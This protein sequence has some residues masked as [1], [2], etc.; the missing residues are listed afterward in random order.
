MQRLVQIRFQECLTNDIFLAAYLLHPNFKGERLTAAQK[1]QAKD[2]I[3][4]RNS[5]FLNALNVFL[6]GSEP[7]NEGIGNATLRDDFNPAGWWK[8]GVL[9]GFN[10]ELAEFAEELLDAVASIAALERYFSTLGF[11]YG[12][13]RTRF[14]VDKAGRIATLYRVFRSQW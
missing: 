7:Y 8:A 3:C 10:S 14:G 13:L 5:G 11:I 6:N 1:R 12:A 9:T 2:F 4:A